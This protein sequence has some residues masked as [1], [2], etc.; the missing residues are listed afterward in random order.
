MRKRHCYID[1]SFWN[2]IEDKTAFAP[3]NVKLVAMLYAEGNVTQQEANFIERHMQDDPVFCDVVLDAINQR[4]AYDERQL[5]QFNAQYTP[6][7]WDEFAQ[8]YVRHELTEEHEALVNARVYVDGDYADRIEH[9][10]EAYQL[11]KGSAPEGQIKKVSVLEAQM[12]GG[13]GS[14]TTLSNNTPLSDAIRDADYTGLLKSTGKAN[15]SR[16]GG[17]GA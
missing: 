9:A 1:T 17:R 10:R 6:E 7:Q 5:T 16:D 8:R 13:A 4:D 14:K 11:E 15:D 3:D 12:R 2:I